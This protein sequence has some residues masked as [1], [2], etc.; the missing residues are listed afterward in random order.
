MF[1]L[2]KNKIFISLGI[3]ACII[4]ACGSAPQAQENISTAVA[5]TVQAQNSLTKV[6]NIPTLTP[7][8]SI[9]STSTTNPAITSTSA[10]AVGAPNCTVSARLA[11]EDPPDGTLLKPG[12]TF[13]KTWSLEN[14]GTCTWDSSYKLVYW[15]GD[16]MGGL[17][18]Y[19]LPEAV[20][21]NEVKD[22]SIY[23]KAPDVEGGAKGYWSIQTP[24]NTYFGVGATSDPFYVQVVVSSAT[25][26]KY[27]ITSVTY[28]LA[29]DPET[30]CPRNVWYTV[31]ATITTNGPYSFDYY[32]DQKDG[33][34]S[35]IKT[36]KFTEAG[37]QTIA[38]E[39]KVGRGD[40]PNPRWMQIIVT[41]PV[42]QEY[43]QFVF[44]NNC[45]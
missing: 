1:D 19:P 9:D 37:S 12:E 5:Q 2:Q 7:V 3:L 22:I 21:P 42:H 27:G 29:R 33:N 44:Q 35:G 13:L 34:H 17:T 30:G 11:G 38:R 24:W 26:P 32:W 8:P 40:S 14:T 23:L 36:M 18:S 41:S 15:S 4:S 39:W 28:S 16:L 31:Y 43:D 6:A 20:A 25:N 45:P 10:P